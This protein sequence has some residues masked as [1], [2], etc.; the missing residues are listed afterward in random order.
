MAGI[1]SLRWLITNRD[2]EANL[3][4]LVAAFGSMWRG[5]WGWEGP[6]AGLGNGARFYARMARFLM[7]PKS[8]VADSVHDAHRDAEIT[9]RLVE[10]IGSDVICHDAES[11]CFLK[12]IVESRAT[13]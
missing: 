11:K 9:L 10:K 13:E 12:L 5:F 1:G 8:L 4:G 3:K 6:E 7:G 2:L